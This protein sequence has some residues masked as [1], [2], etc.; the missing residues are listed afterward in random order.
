MNED[1][2]KVLLLLRKIAEDDVYDKYIIII[3]STDANTRKTCLWRTLYNEKG[4]LVKMFVESFSRTCCVLIVITA[5]AWQ[6]I[7]SN[8]KFY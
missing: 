1:T 8:I 6:P 4:V 2:Q 7:L 5:P 3:Q